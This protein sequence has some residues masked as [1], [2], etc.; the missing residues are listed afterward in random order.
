VRAVREQS[1][2]E[3]AARS[4]A[5]E[6]A[7]RA[8]AEAAAARRDAEEA[9]RDA[10]EARR[11]ADE[12]RAQRVEADERASKQFAALVATRRWRAVQLALRPADRARSAVKRRGSRARDVKE[13]SR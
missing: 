9:R 1:E 8:R 11:G 7:V 2:A 5:E 6:D 3:A 13:G 4:G 12:A 10:E